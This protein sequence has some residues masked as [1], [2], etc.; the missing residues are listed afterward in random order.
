ML[1]GVTRTANWLVDELGVAV[2]EVVALD[3]G[4]CVEYLLCW[5]AI[6]AVGGVV[7]KVN[8]N[9]SGEVLVGCVKVRQHLPSYLCLQQSRASN[10]GP[11][12]THMLQNNKV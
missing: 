2:G 1:D 4:N 11:V 9:L 8:Y 10:A 3:G 5:W 7:A 6:E 12:A